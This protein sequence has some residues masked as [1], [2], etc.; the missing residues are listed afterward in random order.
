[1]TESAVKGKGKSIF[2]NDEDD[3]SGAII[4][5]LDCALSPCLD[6]FFFEYDKEIVESIYPNPEN[7][8]SI[9]KNEPFNVFVFFN[10]KVNYEN[11]NSVITLSCY[12][13]T[14]NNNLKYT[15]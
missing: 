10:D 9:L 13:S 3:V 12:D 11:L 8:P 6:D 1:M 5:L 14:I 7:I 2:V 4:G 15:V